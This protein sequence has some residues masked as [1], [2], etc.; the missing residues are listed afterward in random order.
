MR[1]SALVAWGRARTR[2]PRADGTGPAVMPCLG[3]GPALPLRGTQ[4]RPVYGFFWR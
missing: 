3:V 4:N 2:G 1:M